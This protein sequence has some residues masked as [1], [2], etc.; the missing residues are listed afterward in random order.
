VIIIKN[1]DKL[2]GVSISGDNYDLD[3]LVNALYTITID[4]FTQK[5]AKHIRISTRVLGLCYDVRHALQ[6]DREVELVDNGM[7]EDKM[8]FHSM[9][10]PKNNVYYKCNYLYPEMFFIMLAL[11]E[12]VKI[13]IKELSK[14][15]SYFTDAFDKNTIWD[16]TIATIRS[17]QGEF[18]KCV[19]ELLTDNSFARWLKLMNND[20]IYIE[21]IAG[22]YVDL[23][24]IKYIAMDK[25][26][27][28][29]NLNKIAKR[30]AEFS[31]DS[32]HNEIKEVVVKAAK[33]YGCCEGDIH[34]Q[35]MEYPEDITW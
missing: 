15:K 21:E 5:H 7:D 26:K 13:R 24:N 23:L 35:G 31:N 3:K 34:I 33:E 29:K 30:I 27:R 2:A 19:K 20:Y 28:L 9:I 10:T 8:K 12:L 1:T 18:M 32:D 22:Q 16:D 6:G 11:N 25:E 17:F 4:E 14:S